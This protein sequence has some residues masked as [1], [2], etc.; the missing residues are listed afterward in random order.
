MKTQL[1]V[2]ITSLM[3]FTALADLP[4]K[5]VRAI[6]MVESS[7]RYGKIDGDNFRAKGPLQIHESYYRDAKA[8]KP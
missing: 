5:F 8:F 6:H 4:P 7:G 2:A 1:A 3:G